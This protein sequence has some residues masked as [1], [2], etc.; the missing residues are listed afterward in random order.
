MSTIKYGQLSIERVNAFEDQVQQSL[1]TC[2][3]LMLHRHLIP[4]QYL[5]LHRVHQQSHPPT[6]QILQRMEGIGFV[7]IHIA[8]KKR[9]VHQLLESCLICSLTRRNQHQ[10]EF[11]LN[12]YSLSICIE[13]KNRQLMCIQQKVPMLERR[14]TQASGQRLQA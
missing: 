6:S 8:W 1:V 12:P 9:T 3:W 4:Q 11:W 13:I 10:M 7:Q 2:F 5:R 14:E